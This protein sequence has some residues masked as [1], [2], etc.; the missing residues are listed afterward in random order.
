M[1]LSFISSSA[2]RRRVVERQFRKAG[3]PPR[4]GRRQERR[5]HPT[6]AEERRKARALEEQGRGL[7]R[8]PPRPAQRRKPTR[9]TSEQ[10]RGRVNT[11]RRVVVVACALT[12]C[13]KVHTQRRPVFQ[14]RPGKPPVPFLL[15]ARYKAYCCPRH[16]WRAAY[17]RLKPLREPWAWCEADDCGEAFVPSPLGRPARF[18]TPRCRRRTYRA[19]HPARLAA[20]YDIPCRGCGVRIAASG[21]PGRP[22]TR[23]AGCRVTAPKTPLTPVQ[24]GSQEIEAQR[25]RDLSDPEY[26]EWLRRHGALP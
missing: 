20:F 2:K 7:R 6:P 22:P 13:R 21:R 5:S 12:S 24:V 23:C 19:L 26:A 25:R 16:R 3:I 4:R 18:C 10:Y 11:A 14:T 9:R 17:E 15:L 8:P 1:T